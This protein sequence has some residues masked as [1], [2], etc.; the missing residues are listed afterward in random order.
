MR[1]FEEWWREE[2]LPVVLATASTEGRP[3]P[4]TVVLEHFDDRGFVFWTSSESRKGKELGANPRAALVFLWERR[5]Q[6]RVEGRVERVSEEE[7]ETHWSG[8]EVKRQIAA[9]RRGAPV[10]DRDEPEKLVR[11]TLDDPPR[12]PFWVGYRVVP[13]AIEVRVADEEFVHDRI[14]YERA[15]DGWQRTQL[16]P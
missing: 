12:P 7:N 9:F 14:R 5:R 13:D 2:Q 11:E 15:A 3:S 8:R 1:V 4:R 10:A 6:L 16:Q